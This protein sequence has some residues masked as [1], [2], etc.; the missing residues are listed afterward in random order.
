MQSSESAVK[1]RASALCTPLRATKIAMAWHYTGH[2]SV[3]MT[4]RRWHVAPDFLLNV[5]EKIVP[6]PA[7][8]TSGEPTDTTTDTGAFSQPRATISVYVLSLFR[9]RCWDSIAGA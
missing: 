1:P 2:K 3:A 6:K 5:V 9:V 8:F 4:V 7:T